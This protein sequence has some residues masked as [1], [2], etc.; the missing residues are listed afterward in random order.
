MK[1]EYKTFIKLVNQEQEQ[2][3]L[4]ECGKEGWE[5]IT[6]EEF[7]YNIKTKNQYIKGLMKRVKN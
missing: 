4:D 2:N 3:F 7:D 5:I 6:Y 1:Y